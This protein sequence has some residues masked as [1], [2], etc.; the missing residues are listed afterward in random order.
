MA[1]M[2]G[3]GVATVLLLAASLAS[4]GEAVPSKPGPPGAGDV[5]ITEVAPSSR[6]VADWIELTHEGLASVTLDGCEIATGWTG[7]VRLRLPA[8]VMRPG[9]IWVIASDVFP[10]GCGARVDLLLPGLAL[11][12]SGPEAVGLA[13]PAPDG[14]DGPA[15]VD[16]DRV[17]FDF[18]RARADAGESLERCGDPSAAAS[19]G[20]DPGWTG[21]TASPWCSALGAV[22]R[23][24]PGWAG[25]CDAAS[26]APT[27]GSS[28]S[29]GV[30]LGCSRAGQGGA[31]GG[32]GVALLAGVTA[33]A[34]WAFRRR[35]G[36]PRPAERPRRGSTSAG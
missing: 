11:R 36:P 6:L 4:A 34:G 1:R 32:A 10:Q 2:T 30:G 23:G 18:G 28:G 9:E 35:T 16:V 12:A 14:T 13:C 29:A 7:E 22:D 8:I 19:A 15:L 17:G 27:G 26:V 25:T 20:L 5:R 3:S 21:S 33:A 31:S 24:T